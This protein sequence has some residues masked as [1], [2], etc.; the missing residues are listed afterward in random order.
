MTTKLKLICFA[1]FCSLQI[2]AQTRQEVFTSI[3]KLADKASG[4][5][6][7]TND[8]FAKKDDKLGKQVITEKVMAVNTIP[9][10]KSDYEWISRATEMSWNDFFDFLIFSEYINNNLQIV[11]LN[12]NKPFKT[13]HFT[14]DETSGAYPS[15]SDRFEF[16][17][18]TKDKNELTQLLNR[19][20]DLKEKKPES[21]FNQ[22]ISKF[23]KEQ[24]ISWLTEKIQNN[25]AG[26]SYTT[27][28][29]LISIDA[30]NL[31]FDY[32]NM[33][34]RKYRETIP[35]A[36]ES[37]NKY[38]QFTFNN[39][40]CISKSYAFGMIQKKDEIS[41]DDTSFLNINTTNE[42]LISNIEF[43]MKHLATFCNNEQVKH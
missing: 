38:T 4:E 3:Q 8:V 15:T 40:I 23:S 28:I 42:E 26:D 29:K 9:K 35:M 7:K 20:Y 16:Y 17:I 36:I 14:N 39:K 19:L 43:A 30:C 34:G 37:V 18:L 32:S 27:S 24:T 6:V 10:G 31:I 25:M 33:V 12:F 41:Y 22:E 13:E 11:R 21:L 1:L 5:K 2:N